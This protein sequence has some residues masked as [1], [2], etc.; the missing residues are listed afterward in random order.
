MRNTREV[1]GFRDSIE[2]LK[3]LDFHFFLLI[4][5]MLCLILVKNQLKL[6]ISAMALGNMEECCGIWTP[7]GMCVRL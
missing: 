1:A 7:A 5:V 4:S 6:E 3:S 2:T